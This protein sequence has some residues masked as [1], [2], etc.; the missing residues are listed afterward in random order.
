MIGHRKTAIASKVT[1]KF[2]DDESNIGRSISDQVD[3]F[4]DEVQVKKEE[5]D[6]T[7]TN[8]IREKI[9]EDMDEEELYRPENNVDYKKLFN[10][11]KEVKRVESSDSEDLVPIIDDYVR[12][13]F[14]DNIDRI[15]KL[16]FQTFIDRRTKELDTR[17]GQQVDSH[18]SGGYH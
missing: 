4:L 6:Q 1:K 12:D 8:K 11:D 17:Q 15:T 3:K 13:I 9:F 2:K 16:V 14:D 5:Y 7:Y 10:G 18:Y